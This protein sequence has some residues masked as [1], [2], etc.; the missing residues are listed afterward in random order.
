M[1]G[2]YSSRSSGFM[3]SQ[4]TSVWLSA[5]PPSTCQH[6]SLHLVLP[7]IW[8]NSPSQPHLDLL[9][10]LAV[11]EMVFGLISTKI[12]KVSAPPSWLL[13]IFPFHLLLQFGVHL[14]LVFASRCLLFAVLVSEGIL[15]GL[16]NNPQ[17]QTRAAA[18]IL[19]TVLC[20]G[21][22]QQPKLSHTL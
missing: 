2:K 5:V 17:I 12:L 8:R 14:V 19:L 13:G 11:L 10:K 9:F 16:S 1:G 15:Y 3:K 6:E 22:I 18:L 7:P 20:T 4:P 21:R